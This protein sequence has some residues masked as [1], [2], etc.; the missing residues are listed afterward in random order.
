[1]SRKPTAAGPGLALKVTSDAERLTRLTRPRLARLARLAQ[2]LFVADRADFTL[3]ER[4]LP[5][6][7]SVRRDATEALRSEASERLEERDSR[8]G[9]SSRCS[10]GKVEGT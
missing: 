2:R 5:R 9:T 1:M 3:P 4:C 10:G 8:A 7:R 6:T